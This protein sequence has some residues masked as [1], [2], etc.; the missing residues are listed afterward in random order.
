MTQLILHVGTGKTGSTAIQQTLTKMSV[1]LSEFGIAYLPGAVGHHNELETLV[2]PVKRWHRGHRLEFGE[3]EQP[4]L[5]RAKR[6]VLSMRDMAESHCAVV[7]SAEYIHSL[8]A[9]E[10]RRLVDMFEGCIDNASAVIYI[11]RPSSFVLLSLQQFLKL[12]HDITGLLVQKYAFKVSIENWRKTLGPGGLT[13]REFSPDALKDGDVVSDFFHVLGELT[14]R[15]IAV[16]PPDSMANSSLSAEECIVLQEFKRA[17][18]IDAT[19]LSRLM[20]RKINAAV[21]RAARGVALTKLQFR[22]DIGRLIDRHHHAEIELLREQ[23]GID[24]GM[25][26]EAPDD[27]SRRRLDAAAAM[28]DIADLVVHDVGQLKALRGR[29]LHILGRP[30][31]G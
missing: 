28:V 21:A 19:L 23:F 30:A 26:I 9:S 31:P 20:N 18:K 16:K 1:E 5:D 29:A 11:R 17:H 7:I 2:R 22:D 24:F 15:Q 8:Q 13:V 27:E 4:I 3:N 14:G 10:S 25:R 6:L 12:E